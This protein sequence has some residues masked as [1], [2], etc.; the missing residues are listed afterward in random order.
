[1]T[2]AAA[3]RPLRCLPGRASAAPSA[4]R[5]DR[6]HLRPASTW[7][8][9][10]SQGRR[11]GGVRDRRRRY[12]ARVRY[13]ADPDV[14]RDVAKCR[15]E[16]VFH[17]A[18][19]IATPV[20]IIGRPPRAEAPIWPGERSSPRPSEVREQDPRSCGRNPRNAQPGISSNGPGGRSASS[21]SAARRSASRR[22]PRITLDRVGGPIIGTHSFVFRG[23]R[24]SIRSARSSAAAPSRS[25]GI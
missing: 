23:D 3:A 25:L 12:R 18:A 21:A 10:A 7:R 14:R 24:G 16:R 4:M 22:S 1:M 6:R 2:A 11:D 8:R 19:R 9:R 20:P 15:N 17:S 5:R 13:D